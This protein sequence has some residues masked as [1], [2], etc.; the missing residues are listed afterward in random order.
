MLRDSRDHIISLEEK[1][2]GLEIETAKV[3]SL[4]K[5]VGRLKKQIKK[6]EKA[7]KVMK[8]EMRIAGKCMKNVVDI[9]VKGIR[10]TDNLL[11][12]RG[13]D[14][15]MME[16]ENDLNDLNDF[17]E[18]EREEEEDNDDEEEEG[19]FTDREAMEIVVESCS[20]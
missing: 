9:M 3:S 12:K 17:E 6:Y 20:D 1:I 10:K 19:I 16:E 4:E 11:R 5:E 14:S 2:K 18:E 7:M 15:D 8:S 13:S